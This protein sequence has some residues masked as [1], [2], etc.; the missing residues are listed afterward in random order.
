MGVVFGAA[1]AVHVERFACTAGATVGG[2]TVVGVVFGAASAVH[3]RFA[4]TAGATVGVAATVG[5]PVMA[6]MRT[7]RSFICACHSEPREVIVVRGR[8]KT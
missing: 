5:V 8:C 6:N 4:R 3:E 1:S 2:T 7:R